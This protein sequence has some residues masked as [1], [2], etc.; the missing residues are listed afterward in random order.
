MEGINF[1]KLLKLQA[2]KNAQRKKQWQEYRLKKDG[3][4]ST[5]V[6]DSIVKQAEIQNTV[7]EEVE[8]ES[9]KQ[10]LVVVESGLVPVYEDSQKRNVVNA[11]EL[12]A[13]LQSKRQFANWIQD[14]IEKYGF[15][16]DKDYV[17]FNSFVKNSQGG[18]PTTEY[19]L[20]MDTAKEIAMVENNEQGRLVRKYFIECEKRL[21]FAHMPM[22]QIKQVLLNPD[23]IIMLAQEL[24]QEQAKNKMLLNKVKEDRPKVQFA[25]AVI[26]SPDSIPV[27]D[28]AKILKQNGIDIGRTRLFQW[29]RDNGYLI[30]DGR[31]H[32]SPTQ[33]A[34]NLDL[35]EVKI[36]QYSKPN[37]EVGIGRITLVTGKGQIY[38]VN[39]FLDAR[40]PC[41]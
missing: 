38:F 7:K 15:S 17:V 37:G 18:R 22:D 25:D 26:A 35:F 9:S 27:G 14:R 12:H 6:T 39:K 3:F 23:T 2:E 41:K 31:S 10:N 20:T 11:R 19:L 32:N 13:F 28:L 16:Q 33:Y 29:L 4:D 8:M 40:K 24:K 21:R 5:E 30:Q 1:G 36:G 34:M